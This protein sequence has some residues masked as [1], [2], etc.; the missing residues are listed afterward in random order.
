[1]PFIDCLPIIM[2]HALKVYLFGPGEPLLHIFIEMPLVAFEGEHIIG[3]TLDDG[4]GD[5]CLTAHGIDSHDT[6]RHIQLLQ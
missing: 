5:S 2:R 6:T 3:L 4:L 1:M